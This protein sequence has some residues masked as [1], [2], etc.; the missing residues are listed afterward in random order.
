MNATDSI[1]KLDTLQ[2]NTT[3]KLQQ[4][5]AKVDSISNHSLS[6]SDTTNATHKASK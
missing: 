4:L 6:I 3:L 5:Q 2:Q 1:G